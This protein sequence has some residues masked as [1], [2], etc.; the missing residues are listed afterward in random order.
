MNARI[1]TNPSCRTIQPGNKCH[2]CKTA[3]QEL[4]AI[5]LQSIGLDGTARL[6]HQLIDGYSILITTASGPHRMPIK[7]PDLVHAAQL[8]LP[9]TN[10]V[11]GLMVMDALNVASNLIKAKNTGHWAGWIIYLLEK[12]QN[13]ADIASFKNVISDLRQGLHATFV[14]HNTPSST[15]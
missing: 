6:T 1:C 15:P 10:H 3:T 4:P 13:H 9:N 8:H 14:E 12:L 11:S 2:L 5:P 7:I